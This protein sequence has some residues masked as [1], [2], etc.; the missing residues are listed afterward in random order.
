MRELSLRYNINIIG[1][2]HLT[3]KE[4]E[5]ILNIAYLFA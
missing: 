4:D 2:S 5:R 3:R 1:G